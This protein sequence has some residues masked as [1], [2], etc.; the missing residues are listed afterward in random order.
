M[1]HCDRDNRHVNIHID[2]AAV[3]HNL[4]RARAV[5]PEKKIFSV[6]KSDAYGHGF[7]QVVTA[8]TLSDAFAVANVAE[9][10]AVRLTE[11]VKPVLVLQGYQSTSQLRECIRADLWPVIHHAEQLKMLVGTDAS[12][13]QCWVKVDTGMGR[14]GIEP[15]RLP[16]VCQ[17]LA[18][19]SVRVVGILTHLASADRPTAVLCLTDECPLRSAS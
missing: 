9:G 10:V 11:A 4:N 12:S 3:R 7:E 15:G 19:Q 16:A 13:L 5:A 14:L 1:T 17:E 6:V 18:D 8:L 2:L